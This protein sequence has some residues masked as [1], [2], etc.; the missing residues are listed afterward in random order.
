M[1]KTIYQKLK[2]K[3]YNFFVGV[4]CSGIKDFIAEVQKDKEN[5]YVP[6]TREDTAVALA[7]GAYFAGKKPLVFM[8]NSGLGNVVN[9]TASLLKPY[10]IPIHFLISLRKMS[11]EHKFMYKI[12][13]K[14]ATLLG[15]LSNITFIDTNND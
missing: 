4:P 3:G 6:A 13:K 5:I 15:C 11:F 9:I 2:A 10:G 1:R 14:L 7:V 8:Q 12:T